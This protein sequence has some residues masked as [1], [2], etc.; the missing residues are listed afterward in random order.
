MTAAIAFIGASGLVLIL[1]GI[2]LLSR[3]RL[4]SRVEPY[5]S[6]LRGRPSNLLETTSS[7]QRSIDVWLAATVRRI[8]PVPDEDLGKRLAAAGLELTPAD[9][10]LEQVSWGFAATVA[11][12]LLAG[13]GLV[14]G[15]DLDPRVLPVASL[16]F[17]VSG[18]L[19]RDWWLTRQIEHR[20]TQL[21]NELPTAI[22]LV[23]LCIMSG[24]SVPAAFARVGRLLK[25]GIG[26]ELRNVVADVRAGSPVIDAL[27]ALKQRVDL[28]GVARLVDALSTGIE[29]GAPLADVLR[30]QAEDGREMRRRFLL[31]AGGRREVAMLV[32]VVFLI[33][34]VVVVYAL[35]PG[36]VSLDLLVP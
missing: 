28:P 24:E 29:R 12:W 25:E 32:P 11:L 21:Q 30:A 22:D 34:P 19:A 17:L 4:A 15:A 6:G 35:V 16:L 10:R 13:V 27:E 20:R 31:E 8:L 36:L 9:F 1:R 33:M 26:I 7:A 18:F 2:P 23:T 3:P 14:A 5:L